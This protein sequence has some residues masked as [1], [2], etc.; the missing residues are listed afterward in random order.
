M[1]V[2]G[3]VYCIAFLGCG[4]FSLLGQTGW[5]LNC[6]V[7]PPQANATNFLATWAGHF[8]ETPP[9][10]LATTVNQSNLSEGCGWRGFQRGQ[11][12]TAKQEKTEDGKAKPARVHQ[13]TH[14]HSLFTQLRMANRCGRFP[15]S[16]LQTQARPSHAGPAV[17]M[18]G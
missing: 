2:M 10:L 4:V 1:S 9:W 18:N 11:G 17:K 7:S 6:P 15:G 14:T 13:A 3:K 5:C 8:S 16:I 12:N